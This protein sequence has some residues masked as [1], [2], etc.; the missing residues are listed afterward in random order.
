MEKSQL[1][2]KTGLQT[3]TAL[4]LVTLTIF[5]ATACGSVPQASTPTPSPRPGHK[6][7][8]VVYPAQ[9]LYTFG[10]ENNLN[11]SRKAAKKF[12]E[13][14]DF[15]DV[16]VKKNGDVIIVVTEQQR[17]ERIQKNDKWIETGEENFQQV[18][19][20]YRYEINSDGTAMT[21]WTDRNL[22]P[23]G[24]DILTVTPIEYGYNY[25]LKGNTGIWDMTITVRNCHTDQLIHQYQFSQ[26]W[27]F[28]ADQLGD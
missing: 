9:F 10:F 6:T 16:Y 21:I 15:T 14:G 4:L 27:G 23:T 1:R 26:G 28:N 13:T 2:Q 11:G 20:N 7:E 24:G 18:S 12:K 22:T 19:S 3:T 5:F 17:Q 8:Q 25:Y